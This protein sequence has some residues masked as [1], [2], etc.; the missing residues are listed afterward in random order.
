MKKLYR[1]SWATKDI[2]T[3]SLIDE[4][5]M[6]DGATKETWLCKDSNGRKFS[7]S[8]G[9]WQFSE[10]EAWK[11]YEDDLNN[12]CMNSFAALIAAR[13]EHEKAIN[14]HLRAKQ[15]VLELASKE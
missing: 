3:A 12:S 5:N 1:I 8:K 9:Q 14:E 7:C 6:C 11:E 2:E 13:N 4:H 15:K 10:L